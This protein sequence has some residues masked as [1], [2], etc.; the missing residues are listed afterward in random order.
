MGTQGLGIFGEAWGRGRHDPLA[1][2]FGYDHL[3]PGEK[4]AQ[5]M[6]CAKVLDGFVTR[7]GSRA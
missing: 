7:D 5:V 4:Q 6:V 3:A 2:R 1:Q